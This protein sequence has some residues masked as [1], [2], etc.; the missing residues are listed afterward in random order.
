MKPT[1]ARY[2]RDLQ[3]KLTL[4]RLAWHALMS[5]NF[6]VYHDAMTAFRRCSKA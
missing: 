3:T 5:R 6:K 2:L 1:T 4:E